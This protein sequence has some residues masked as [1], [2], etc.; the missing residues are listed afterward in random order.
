MR[1]APGA[2]AEAIQYHYDVAEDF[3]RLWLDET[4][5]YSSALW[6]GEGD[7]LEAAQL[8]KL[9]YHIEQARACGVRRVLDIG[10]G[11]GALLHRLA[12]TH[13]VEQAVG[14]TLSA[15]QSAHI[16]R[17]GWP[18][19]EVRQESWWLHRPAA[20]YD[21]I[22]S[23]GAFEHFA[24]LDQ[25]AGDK[26][27]GYR[28]FFEHCHEW[29]EPG[30]WLS[31]QTMSYENSE[32]EDFSDYFKNEIFPESDLPHLA[33]IAQASEYLFEIVT[34]RGDRDHYVRTIQ[35]WRHRLRAR[36][37]EAATIVGESTVAKYDKYLQL[38]M[39]G[40]RGATMNLLR[41]GFRRIDRPRARAKR[42]G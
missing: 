35:A 13:G 38:A 39:L 30:G 14:L 18:G 42:R 11:W 33:E 3:Y 32:R 12:A 26:A 19:V 8:R 10:C 4:M 2:S 41:I 31:L 37:A 25:G 1:Q 5:T 34:V 7:T 16:Q 23:I 21:A 27:E 15:S 24:R 22:V 9:D 40:F 17:K 20:Y 36:W 6:E 29:L 28:A